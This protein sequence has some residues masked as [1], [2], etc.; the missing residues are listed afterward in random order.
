[1]DIDD[2]SVDLLSERQPGVCIQ[3]N[4]DGIT[5]RI[6]HLLLRVRRSWFRS[7][8]PVSV[9]VYSCSSASNHESHVSPTIMY[10]LRHYLEVL[11]FSVSEV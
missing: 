7:L 5:G 3:A 8:S 2:I 6:I 4:L 11:A 1:M 9:A 10:V